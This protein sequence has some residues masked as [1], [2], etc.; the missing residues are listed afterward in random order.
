VGCST[1]RVCEVFNKENRIMKVAVPTRGNVVDDHFGHCE[2]YTVFSI[3]EKRAIGKVETL[4]APQGCGCKSNIAGILQ[5]MGVGVM[6]AGNM[7]DGALRVLT[8]HGIEV[9]RGNQGDVREVTEAYLQGKISDSGQGC[10][11]HGGHGEDHQC[12]G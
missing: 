7:G 9:Y 10:H 5:E 6:L 3:D 11:Q 8:M 12:A 4:P 2:A 1:D